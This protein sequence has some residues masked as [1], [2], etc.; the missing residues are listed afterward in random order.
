M[1]RA[2]HF[3]DHIEQFRSNTISDPFPKCERFN[4]WCRH[5]WPWLGWPMLRI[6]ALCRAVR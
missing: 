5:C 2:Y 1:K 4:I 6:S 3:T